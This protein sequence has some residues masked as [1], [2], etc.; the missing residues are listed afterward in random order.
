MGGISSI[1]VVWTAH[2]RPDRHPRRVPAAGVHHGARQA[3]HSQL[4][5][6]ELRARYDDPAETMEIEPGEATA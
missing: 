5:E 2:D 1:S 4:S 6:A 3:P